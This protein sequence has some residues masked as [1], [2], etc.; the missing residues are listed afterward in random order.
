MNA[1]AATIS[2]SIHYPYEGYHG[3]SAFCQLIVATIPPG[4]SLVVLTEHPEN[5]GTSVTNRSE[6][7]ATKVCQQFGLDPQ[8]CLFL[9]HYPQEHYPQS[10]GRGTLPESWSLVTY[11]WD[12]GTARR[13]DWRS[14]SREQVGDLY[15]RF[16]LELGEVGDT[17]L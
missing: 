1:N 2:Y 14:I 17:L 9:E 15:T 12:D 8:T 11:N 3:S 16:G 6:Y 10:Q 5:A 13:P 7:L 4:T